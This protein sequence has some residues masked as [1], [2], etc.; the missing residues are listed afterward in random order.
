MSA[1]HVAV[2]Q[3]VG[4]ESK[5]G[6]LVRTDVDTSSE[7]LPER[8]ATGALVRILAQVGTRANYEMITGD[9]PNSGWV[10]T[11]VGSKALLV[12]TGQ[13]LSPILHADVQPSRNSDSAEESDVDSPAAGSDS[14][15]STQDMQ[16]FQDEARR[17]EAMR[18][19]MEQFGQAPGG[20]EDKML[21]GKKISS[22]PMQTTQKSQVDLP[23]NKIDEV[24]NQLLEEL[25][26][27][28]KGTS[29]QKMRTQKSYTSRPPAFALLKGA[30]DNEACLCRHCRLPIG[31]VS[32]SGK[33]GVGIYHGECAAQRFLQEMRE[34]EE[35]RKDE[36]RAEKKIRREEYSIGW[37]A[38]SIPLNA[39]AAEIL[40]CQSIPE[41]M[42]CLV[43]EEDSTGESCV[44][45]AGTLEPAAAVN[46]EYLS[47]ALEVRRRDGCEPVFSLEPAD[48][49]E[50]NPMQ[51]KRFSPEWL[52]GT[53]LGETMF[54]ADYH[55][56]ELSMGEYE[57]PVMGMKS[58][59]DYYQSENDDHTWNGREW[60]LIKDAEVC[61]SEN[62]VLVPHVKMGVEAREQV[63]T[64]EGLVDTVMTRKDHPLV[65]YADAF[66]RNFDLI[67]ERKSA[68]F[69]LRETAKA[70]VLAKFLIDSQ[71]PLDEYW[72]QLADDSQEVCPMEV[73]QLWNDRH[74]IQ[75]HL[76]NGALVE[77]EHGI[78]GHKRGVYGGV[79][80]GLGRIDVARSLTVSPA[81]TVAT[82]FAP[83]SSLRAS[84][85]PSAD[86][87]PQK[88]GGRLVIPAPR[89]GGFSIGPRPRDER[90][91]DGGEGPATSGL[92]AKAMPVGTVRPSMAMP[93]NRVAVS[94]K[95]VQD[96]AEK[97]KVYAKEARTS[98][99]TMPAGPAA[100]V[101]SHAPIS[102]I[103][104]LATQAQAIEKTKASPVARVHGKLRPPRQPQ[105][106][107]LN[108]DTFN[109]SNIKRVQ[110]G[111]NELQYLDL[112]TNVGHEFWGSLEKGVGL[113]SEDQ[114][115]LTAIFNPHLSD[116]RMEADRFIPPDSGPDYVNKL[117]KLVTNEQVLQQ[118]RK[119]HF[120]SKSFAPGDPGELFPASWTST[121]ELARGEAKVKMT[122]RPKGSLLQHRPDYEAETE[123]FE[124][125]LKSTT[126]VFEN[127][128][129]DGSRFRIYRLGTIEVRTIQ[130]HAGPETIA[131]VYS[132]RKSAQVLPTGG[133][134]TLLKDTEKIAKVTEYVE[135]TAGRKSGKESRG[136]FVV[137]ETQEGNVICT[138]MLEDGRTTWEENPVDLEDRISL[139][140][141]LR[142]MECKASRNT[143]RDL[144]MYVDKEAEHADSAPNF[145]KCKLYSR[146]IFMRARS[147]V[148]EGISRA[149]LETRNVKAMLQSEQ[150]EQ[151][152]VMKARRKPADVATRN[153]RRAGPCMF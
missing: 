117:R 46:L 30:D 143:A 138:E 119:E 88:L 52:A 77:S 99:V 86:L 151:A 142:T 66:S 76:Q 13:Q 45:V 47:L 53:S 17:K 2:W 135:R 22:W 61:I 4:G 43:F 125:I 10:T 128:T 131:V 26:Q 79:S 58:C 50:K 126:A 110:L 65:K 67:A 23:G 73:P 12:K 113:R 124:E 48:V 152:V 75:L 64:E 95:G 120:C 74:Y 39:R 96:S 18:Q 89:V 7:E 141:V 6:I 51:V 54:Q 11:Q 3:V 78:D 136:Y 62:N 80:F 1:S 103:M 31:D 146:N 109:L 41:G 132:I 111:G 55:L 5:G 91:A 69:H 85:A 94:L 81:A 87:R 29:T 40:A 129:E 115:L 16:D 107:D 144:K 63:V 20:T 140:K 148:S 122:E 114:A 150:V 59:F 139:A 149:M 34:E 104:S 102:N 35:D 60:F 56:K 33:N 108:L 147:H 70:T 57:Q 36:I 100:A 98:V 127:S 82:S 28:K 145:A 25:D 92:V 101:S 83:P 105:G 32:C 123:M 71:V 106:V 84:F 137:L 133:T 121:F 72:F 14:E 112:C 9:G 93:S 130:E 19:Y 68:I 90:A 116:R 38:D 49:H 44:R 42:C 24:R 15:A 153:K 134:D 21:G 118:Q 27:A 37:S 97:A 8:L